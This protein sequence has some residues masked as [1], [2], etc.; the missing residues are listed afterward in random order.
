MKPV[1]TAFEI[2]CNVMEIDEQA[3]P[4]VRQVFFSGAAAMFML[5]EKV[6]QKKDTLTRIAYTKEMKEFVNGKNKNS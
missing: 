2:F 6:R 4:A 1:N 5:Q 3:K